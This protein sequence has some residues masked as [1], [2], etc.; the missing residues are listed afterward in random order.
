MDIEIVKI[1]LTVIGGLLAVL[2]GVIAWIGNR[3]H[4]RLDSMSNSLSA[5]EKDL[6][7]DL[8]SLDRRMSQVEAHVDVRNNKACS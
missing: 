2:V 7:K 4:N 5:I 6:R 1:F 8:S 3:I